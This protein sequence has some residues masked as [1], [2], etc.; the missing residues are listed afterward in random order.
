MD[1]KQIVEG[2]GSINIDQSYDVS[3][4]RKL[5]GLANS[6]TATGTQ[7]EEQLSTG[8]SNEEATELAN[9]LEQLLQ[10]MGVALESVESLVKHHLP[11]EYR[12]ME[13]YTFAHIK[14]SLGG[15]G[16]VDRMSKSIEGLIE[17]L[18][19]YAEGGEEE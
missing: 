7:V 3:R 8:M 15:Y 19:E 16:Y 11:N 18:R 2:M 6:S 13:A 5:A 1:K 12:S 10:E 17:D 9:D 14:T 4:I